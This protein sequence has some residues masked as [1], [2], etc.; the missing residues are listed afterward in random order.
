VE[1]LGA[2]L[3]PEYVAWKAGVL[4]A[5]GRA[6]LPLLDH[7]LVFKDGFGEEPAA[8]PQPGKT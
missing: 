1:A 7:R 5:V 4:A 6:P 8:E 3:T 2:R